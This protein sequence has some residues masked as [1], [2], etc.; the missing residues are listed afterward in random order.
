M[1]VC[2]SMQL[3]KQKIKENSSKKKKKVQYDTN[4]L[5][6]VL[7]FCKWRLNIL[8]N[9]VFITSGYWEYFSDAEKVLYLFYVRVVHYAGICTFVP[10]AQFFEENHNGNKT[11]RKEKTR[12]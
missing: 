11:W 1:F 2:A 6:V 3:V 5:C 10:F 8:V 12:E 4:L 7:V 9:S